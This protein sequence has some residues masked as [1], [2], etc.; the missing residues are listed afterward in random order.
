MANSKV[1]RL[2]RW[3][4]WTR[5][6]IKVTGNSNDHDDTLQKYMLMILL[7]FTTKAAI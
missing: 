4:L 1:D 5:H 7:L 3:S 6:C 2:L